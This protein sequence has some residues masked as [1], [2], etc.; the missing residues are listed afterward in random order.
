MMDMIKNR[1][2]I[3]TVILLFT[4]CASGEEPITTLEICSDETIEEA[5]SILG[6]YQS[7]DIVDYITLEG[8]QLFLTEEPYII[9]GTN[10]Y[11]VEYPWRRF[12]TETEGLLGWMIWTAFDFPQSATCFPSPCESTD[13]AEHH[14]GIWESD[15][16]PK[17]A[18]EYIWERFHAPE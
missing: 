5:L 13:N 1:W 2:L 4:S 9:R 3:F 12:L 15:Y 10:Y 8:N 7:S 14:F 16:T 17:P 18:A 6:D 11:P